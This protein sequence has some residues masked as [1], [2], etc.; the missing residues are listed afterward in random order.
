MNESAIKELISSEAHDNAANFDDISAL[1][2]AASHFDEHVSREISSIRE[3]VESS[4]EFKHKM[5]HYSI[6]PRTQ[7][8]EGEQYCEDGL[9]NEKL[10]AEMAYNQNLWKELEDE[11]RSRTNQDG[12]PGTKVSP[13]MA[14]FQMGPKTLDAKFNQRKQSKYTSMFEKNSEKV[15]KAERELSAVSAVASKSFDNFT[16]AFKKATGEKYNGMNQTLMATME[17][18]PALAIEAKK[19]LAAS[20]S[21]ATTMEKLNDDIVTKQTLSVCDVN[22]KAD[23]EKSWS[24]NNRYEIFSFI[25]D[26]APE[27]DK[28]YAGNKFG[29]APEMQALNEEATRKF[30]EKIS[31]LFQNLFSAFQPEGQNEASPSP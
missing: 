28:D 13:L 21:L 30:S 12:S 5:E 19:A 15:K 14:L 7:I 24:N 1:Q 17:K 11:K 4:D 27:L 26:I 23:F 18:H 10:K 6:H 25:E 31:K 3:Q 22:I 29:T 2:I 20:K 8:K 9:L 16:T